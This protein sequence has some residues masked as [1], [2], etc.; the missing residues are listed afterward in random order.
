MN[1]T[2]NNYIGSADA[3]K[4]VLKGGDFDLQLNTNGTVDLKE[5]PASRK[6]RNYQEQLN[7]SQEL[8]LNNCIP[9]K[10]KEEVKDKSHIK[11]AASVLNT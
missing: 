9:V 5:K 7:Q 2:C 11:R 1:S 3:F 8:N 10:Y 6:Y 4:R